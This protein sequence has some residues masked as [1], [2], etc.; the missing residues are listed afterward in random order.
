MGLLSVDRPAVLDVE[1]E[2]VASNICNQFPAPS[3]H[4][5]P[6][7]RGPSP[8]AAVSNRMLVALRRV[9][10]TARETFA[11]LNNSSC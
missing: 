6:C 4:S 10:G 5:P 3:V 8:F 2:K 7:Y 9:H 1:V 11:I